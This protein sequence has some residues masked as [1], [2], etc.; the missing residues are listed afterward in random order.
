[1]DQH[2][3]VYASKLVKDNEW[4]NSNDT[5]NHRSHDMQQWGIFRNDQEQLQKEVG[6]ISINVVGMSF[7]TMQN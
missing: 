6:G 5:N 4:D 7:N 2:W 3:H 1:M